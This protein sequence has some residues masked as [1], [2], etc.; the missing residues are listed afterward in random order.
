MNIFFQTLSLEA[1]SV[2]LFELGIGFGN[3]TST[4]C[5]SKLQYLVLF[6][7]DANYFRIWWTRK[8]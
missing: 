6:Y 4:T 7:D 3:E 8:L 2:M 1:L 5:S